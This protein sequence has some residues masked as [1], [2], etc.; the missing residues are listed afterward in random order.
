ML[1]GAEQLSS[2]QAEPQAPEGW[3]RSDVAAGALG[4]KPRAVRTRCANGQLT[5]SQI[6]GT[7]YIDPACN[8]SLRLATGDASPGPSPAGDELARLSEAQRQR[9]YDRYEILNT[10]LAACED[11]PAAM[12]INRFTVD[13]VSNWNLY[14]PDRRTSRS[15]LLNWKKAYAAGGLTALVDHRGVGGNT[16]PFDAEA[17][18]F[19]KGLYLRERRS[20]GAPSIP[21]IYQHALAVGRTN[22]WRIPSLRRVQDWIYREIDHKTKAAA[23]NPKKFRD[24]CLPRIK[25]D[26]TL[27]PANNCWVAD[28]RIFDF[29]VPRV[30]MVRD[31]ITNRDVEKI[32]WQ[33]PWLTM[34]M[35]TRTWMPVGWVIDFDSPNSRRVASAFILAVRDHGIPEHLIL[36]NGKDFRAHW[37]AGGRQK[38]SDMKYTFDR[39]KTTPLLENL[40]VTV[41]WATPYEPQV[42]TI[43]RFF[44]IMSRQF[45]ANM[46]TYLGNKP[47]NRPQ[48]A[49]LLKAD[50]VDTARFNLAVVREW[51]D[52]WALE[53]Y[54]LRTSPSA[55][56]GG[57]SV[58][59]AFHELRET[60]RPSIRPSDE[61]LAMLLTYE[62]R[63]ALKAEGLYVKAFAGHYRSESP[64]FQRRLAASASH[65]HLHVIYRY[66]ESDPSKVYV[67]DAT[68][69]TFICVATPYIGDDIHPLMGCN[70]DGED[71]LGDAIALQRRMRRE[72][73]AEIRKSQKFA[74]NILL[75][76][77]RAAGHTLGISDDPKTIKRHDPPALKLVGN[78]AEL[79][80]AHEAGRKVARRQQRRKQILTNVFKRTGTDDADSRPTTAE[81]GDPLSNL[82]RRVRQ[83]ETKDEQQ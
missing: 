2:P 61:A 20:H 19:I 78:A 52:K 5:A 75:E 79:E 38:K 82:A 32:T 23:H 77:H 36:D 63:T 7:W 80:K 3:L 47:D 66:V 64:E 25:R 27:V 18:E 35:D 14:H 81:G 6:D 9:A 72:T 40:G 62:K 37:I 8:A 22:G 28:H 24:R 15:A 54:A 65:R 10:Y 58:M 16:A 83:Q 56:C 55:A 17:K 57:M 42:K 31:N 30:R 71:V 76:A 4:L 33:R 1:D 59:R 50:E 74:D 29:A 60:G 46:P 70:A 12:P 67:F 53:D 26:W 48:A 73:N 11:K 51:F 34:F 45:D 68:K 41:H 21:S 44:G 43:E 13:W 69:D 49:G 39:Q